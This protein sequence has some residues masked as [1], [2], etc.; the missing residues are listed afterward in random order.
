[1]VPAN[2][3]AEVVVLRDGAEVARWPLV[4]GPMLHLAVVDELAQ[5]ALQARRQGCSIW[6]RAA[7]PELVALLRLTGLSG[8]IPV[9]GEQPVGG[10][11]VGG[12]QVG[13]QPEE[14][15]QVGV[16]EVVVPHDP[17]A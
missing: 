16:E 17:V 1:M 4:C 7:C 5:L 9:G 6:L 13:G 11:Q 15:E 8:V 3:R 14:F 2:T 10:L 12:L